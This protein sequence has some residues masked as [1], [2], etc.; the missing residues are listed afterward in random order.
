MIHSKIISP[1]LNNRGV[2]I[3]HFIDFLI[4]FTTFLSQFLGLPNLV[5]ERFNFWPF[6]VVQLQESKE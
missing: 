4:E 3:K 5:D 6:P 1:I 2:I